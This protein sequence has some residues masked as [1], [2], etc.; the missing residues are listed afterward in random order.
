M[1]AE[2]TGKY[3]SAEQIAVALMLFVAGEHA[4]ETAGACLKEAGITPADPDRVRYEMLHLRI[5][6]CVTAV[7]RKSVV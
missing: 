4:E 2:P 6:A 5:Y 1:T 3:L 7:D